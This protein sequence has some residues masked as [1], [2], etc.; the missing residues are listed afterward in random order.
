[1]ETDAQRLT[2]KNKKQMKSKSGRKKIGLALGGGGAKGFA[3]IG[4]IKALE[5]SGVPIDFIAGTSIGALVGGLY[6]ASKDIGYVEK[7]ALDSSMD[8]FVSLML[9]F[10]RSG[11][12]VGGEKVLN[13]LKESLD[14]ISFE[15]L[16]I[17]FAAV[18]TEL[19]SGE[20]HYFEKK[21]D[22]AEAIRA[23]ISYP[24]I[25]ALY[26]IKNKLYVDGGLS[27]QVPADKVRLMGA[28]VVIAVDLEN[29]YVFRKDIFSREG[30]IGNTYHLFHSSM[31]VLVRKLA[32]YNVKNANIVINPKVGKF[33]TWSDFDKAK[34][35]IKIGEK[36]T[37]KIISNVR[38]LM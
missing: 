21:G 19:N 7:I 29:D 17:P 10:T 27:C 35:L 31:K 25:F 2:I 13:F 12:L 4:V 11:G 37:K 32:E 24:P 30:A 16:K 36:S 22:V 14:E 33:R 1:M 6:A 34:R 18:A 38:R 23:S 26:K 8:K 9:E 28:D 5:R 20:I 3:H 15:E